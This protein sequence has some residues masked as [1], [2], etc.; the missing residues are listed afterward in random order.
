MAFDSQVTKARPAEGAL[1]IGLD[2]VL[3]TRADMRGI[4]VAG[5]EDFRRANDYDWPALMGG[6][7]HMLRHPDTPNGVYHLLWER[8]R[9]GKATCVYVKCRARDALWYWAMAVVTPI[10]DGALSIWVRPSSTMFAEMRDEYAALKAREA[11][12]LEPAASAEAFRHRIV[13]LGHA[14]YDAYMAAALTAEL[15][16]ADRAKVWPPSPL[17]PRITGISA[18]LREVLAEKHGLLRGFDEISA[19]PMN[20][21]ITASRIEAY[22]G[23][24]ATLAENYRLMAA[25]ITRRLEAVVGRGASDSGRAESGMGERMQ[26]AVSLTLFQIGSARLQ[27]EAIARS[28]VPE[29]ADLPF[30]RS[31][32]TALLT[33]LQGGFRQQAEQ[34]LHEIGRISAAL[35]SSCEDLKRQMLGLDSI[36]VLCRVEA[37]RL[38]GRGSALQSIIDQLGTYHAEIGTRLDRILV[39][40]MAIRAAAEGAVRQAET[41]EA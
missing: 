19:I 36:R 10:P 28:A 39:L 17:L 5:N 29:P 2:E 31:A 32:E 14:D 27:R 6:S 20:L 25:D 16:S 26:A 21:H 38:Q 8:L 7:H 35:K 9:A 12:G 18:W 33:R 23:P 41:A 30:D 13:A 1:E 24:V 4:I 34:G 15:S 11:E 3:S 22:G 40:A 37:G